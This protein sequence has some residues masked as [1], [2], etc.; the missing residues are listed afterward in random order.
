MQGTDKD[1]TIDGT[2]YN[3][4]IYGGLGRDVID[5]GKGAD[6][7]NGGKGDDTIDGGVGEDTIIWN[8]GDD[9]DTVTF[10]DVD[11]LKFGEGITFE[12]LTFYAEGNNLRIVVKGDMTQG[13]ICRDYFIAIII[14]RK[15]SFCRWFC[16]L[17]PA[18][19]TDYPPWRSVRKHLG[20]GLCRHHLRR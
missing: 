10:S 11:H 9:M 16:I 8:L 1:N 4:T 2:L 18:V 15:I 13:V 14:N 5:G 12:D 19:R 17:S 7:I 6:I 3:D 20:N